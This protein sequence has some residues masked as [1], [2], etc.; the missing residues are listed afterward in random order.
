[1]MPKNADAIGSIYWY[2]VE[3]QSTVSALSRHRNSTVGFCKLK[4]DL[5]DLRHVL[6]PNTIL[7]TTKVTEVKAVT[8]LYRNRLQD[9]KENRKLINTTQ[10]RKYGSHKC[11]VRLHDC[12]RNQQQQVLFSLTT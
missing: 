5:C 12:F 10:N 1:M 8:L 3:R 9:A 2:K 11:M 7:L 6:D 4:K